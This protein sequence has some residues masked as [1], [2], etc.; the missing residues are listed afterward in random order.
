VVP[1]GVRTAA[2]GHLAPS[3]VCGLRGTVDGPGEIWFPF[4]EFATPYLDSTRPI[5]EAQ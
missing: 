3:W 2:T 4:P 5:D 1:C